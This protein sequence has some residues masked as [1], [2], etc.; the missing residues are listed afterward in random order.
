[1][2]H[3]KADKALRKYRANSKA[4]GS[5]ALKEKGFPRGCG[6]LPHHF[7]PATRCIRFPVLYDWIIWI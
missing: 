7:I 3:G 4:G 6:M 5:G 2:V 1:M